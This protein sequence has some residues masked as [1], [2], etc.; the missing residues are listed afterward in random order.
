MD[1]ET[2]LFLGRI[3][4]EIYHLKQRMEIE[5]YGDSLIYGLRNGF[6]NEIDEHL[7]SVGYISTDKEIALSEILDVI[8][9][10]PEKLDNFKG[11]YDIEAQLEATEISRWD[12][13]KIITKFKA[14]N[15][16]LILIE[17][18]GSGYSPSECKNFDI[19]N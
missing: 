3:L 9:M 7:K 10:D 1:T 19:H 16:F 5:D 11:Y 6:E 13:I 12:A 14:E 2:K 15:R 4:G 18:M 17:K 8:F